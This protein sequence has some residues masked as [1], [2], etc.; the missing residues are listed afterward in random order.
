MKKLVSIIT[1]ALLVI[2][3]ITVTNFVGLAESKKNPL[4]IR[5]WYGM[6]AA[7][8]E[9]VG[10]IIDLFNESQ[11][12]IVVEGM[13]PGNWA[14]LWTKLDAAY[15]AGNPPAVIGFHIQE[16]A[17]YAN[18]GMLEPI[19]DR[20]EKLGL[21]KG[22]FVAG[23]LEGGAYNG[24]QYAVPIDVHPVAM[25]Y[26][27]D[28]FKE[29]GLDPNKPP[30]NLDELISYAKKLTKPD[31]SQWGLGLEQKNDIQFYTFMSIYF[32]FGG[33]LVS[34]EYKSLFNSDE[35]RKAMQFYLDMIYKY[36]VTPP[37]E[38]DARMDFRRKQVAIVFSGP[39]DNAIAGGFPSVEGLNYRTS[40][41]PQI[42]PKMAA[43]Q[44]SHMLATIKQ[45]D[46][47]IVDAAAEFIKFF[48]DHSTEWAKSGMIVVRKSVQVDPIFAYNPYNCGFV[49]SLPFAQF[50]P[51]IPKGW[52]EL[53][54]GAPDRPIM[55]ALQSVCK[56]VTDIDSALARAEKEMNV[57]LARYYK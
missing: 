20:L 5:F 21:D 15:A 57:M 10:R 28:M 31:G 3:M 38:E 8:A 29:A 33:K 46:P 48:S 40:P 23:T 32:Q 45:K 25:Y 43:W 54:E 42:G 56:K 18:K 55:R 47:K 35:A 14:I 11:D 53:F 26:N 36:K 22:D 17:P 51:L 7:D 41:I 34:D 39:W 16:V 13:T 27:V 2:L 49:K 12:R 24:K 19:G 30:K 4:T 9:Y 37:D 44:S 6:G 1:A 52:E 50:M